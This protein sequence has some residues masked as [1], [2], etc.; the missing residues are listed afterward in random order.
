MD[1]VKLIM[2]L[3]RAKKRLLLISFAGVVF[4][5]LSVV[6]LLLTDDQGGNARAGL[7]PTPFERVH[8]RLADMTKLSCICIR[9][10]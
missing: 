4:I 1:P 6:I 2:P 7:K 9:V 10:R 3:S 5:A 8:S